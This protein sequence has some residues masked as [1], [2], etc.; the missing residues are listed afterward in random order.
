VIFF[1]FSWL[2][3]SGVQA[4]IA[5]LE[6]SPKLGRREIHTEANFILVWPQK[7]SEKVEG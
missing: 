3:F 5:L 2:G 7:I 1:D 6:T 4:L